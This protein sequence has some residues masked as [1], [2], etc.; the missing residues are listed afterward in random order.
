MRYFEN[1]VLELEKNIGNDD[2]FETTLMINLKNVLVE[3]LEI[4]DNIIELEHISSKFK[5]VAY[6]TNDNN[7]SNMLS[8]MELEIDAEIEKMQNQ[9]SELEG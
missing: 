7:L 4:Y 6:A 5:N 1:L 9:I 8:N 2:S 3:K